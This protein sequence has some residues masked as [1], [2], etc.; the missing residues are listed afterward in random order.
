MVLVPGACD[1]GFMNVLG[2]LAIELISIVYEWYC[3]WRECT[4]CLKK[5]DPD[6][7]DCNSKKD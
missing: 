5:R 3:L 7:I 6:I 4:L 2:W 1:M